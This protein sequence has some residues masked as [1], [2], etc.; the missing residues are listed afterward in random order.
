MVAVLEREV[1][2]P[3]RVRQF[4]KAVA[5]YRLLS[6]KYIVHKLQLPETTEGGIILPPMVRK[7][8]VGSLHWIAAKV[9]AAS[10]KGR[11]GGESPIRTGDTI[12]YNSYN[13]GKLSVWVDGEMVELPIVREMDIDAVIRE[14][15]TGE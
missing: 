2:T 13:V 10:T 12:I 6:G 8:A 5:R 1:L 7:K 3:K 11:N 15:A 4:I 9:L 14:Q